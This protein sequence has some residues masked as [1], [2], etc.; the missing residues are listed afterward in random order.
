MHFYSTLHSLHLFAS[1]VQSKSSTA[2]IPASGSASALRP[3]T[4]ESIVPAAATGV[5]VSMLPLFDA[6]TTT[7]LSFSSPSSSLNT[8]PKTN[9]GVRSNM[10]CGGSIATVLAI[11]VTAIWF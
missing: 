5:S 3:N 2:P 8:Q 4:V 10:L 6:P 9:N 7:T 11:V 1:V